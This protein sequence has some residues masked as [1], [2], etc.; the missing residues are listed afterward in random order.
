MLYPEFIIY[1][2]DTLSRFDNKGLKQGNWIEYEVKYIHFG[3]KPDYCTI[4]SISSDGTIYENDESQYTTVY[5]SRVKSKND[6]NCDTVYSNVVNKDVI[7][8][9]SFGQYLDNKKSGK[10]RTYDSNEILYK[11]V[12]YRNG[13]VIDTFCFYYQNGQIKMKG[14]I[15]IN[16]NSFQLEKYSEDGNPLQVKEFKLEELSILL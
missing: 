3:L 4:D 7:D 14:T 13:N 12:N 2:N 16:N 11:E 5:Y 6:S 10:W 8:Y 1:R 15:N 9:L